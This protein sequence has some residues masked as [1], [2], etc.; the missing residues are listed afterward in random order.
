[1]NNHLHPG[2]PSRL[3]MLRIPA[4]TSEVMAEAIRLPRKKMEIRRLVSDFLYHVDM[5]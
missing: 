4:P 5:V 3:P 1:M 2:T